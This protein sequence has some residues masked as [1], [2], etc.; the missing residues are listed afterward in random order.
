M[1]S[2]ECYKITRN[3]SDPSPQLILEAKVEPESS[4]LRLIALHISSPHGIS[5][6]ANESQRKQQSI[7][8]C[9]SIVCFLCQLF[10]QC[11]THYDQ[12]FLAGTEDI[13]DLEEGFMCFPDSIALFRCHQLVQYLL[14]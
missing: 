12:G 10:H 1:N 4:R 11:S 3:G 14:L 5:H 8:Y 2:R 7:I 13:I 9:G 6:V